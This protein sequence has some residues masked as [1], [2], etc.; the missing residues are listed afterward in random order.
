M[1]KTLSTRSAAMPR[2]QSRPPAEPR[3]TFYV[4]LKPEVAVEARALAAQAGLAMNAFV[5][6]ALIE[7]STRQAKKAARQ[8]QL[9][10]VR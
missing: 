2:K 10:L 5:E 9:E 7:H 8:D 6:A 3:V 1:M 4:R